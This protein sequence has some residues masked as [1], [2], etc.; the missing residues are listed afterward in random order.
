MLQVTQFHYTAWPD[1]SVPLYPSS[2]AKFIR[3]VNGVND[4]AAPTVVHC[5]WVSRTGTTQ[6]AA[7]KPAAFLYLTSVKII[8]ERKWQ[9]FLVDVW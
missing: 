1:H 6:S 3:T 5:R 2:L 8:T 9:T 7:L 4:Q